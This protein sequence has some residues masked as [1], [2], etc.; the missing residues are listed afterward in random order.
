[1]GATYSSG[2]PM[3]IMSMQDGHNLDLETNSNLARNL[4][5]RA[6]LSIEILKTIWVRSGADPITRDHRFY[7]SRINYAPC[8]LRGPG[9]RLHTRA[10]FHIQKYRINLVIPLPFQWLEGWIWTCRPGYHGADQLPDLEQ[11][12]LSSQDVS[13]HS[14]TG[15]RL[16]AELIICRYH[17]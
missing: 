2:S 6:Q 15:I 13:T 7:A 17:V 9:H 11:I 16:T 12:H 5:G 10:L 8:R 3:V 4:H 14:W 1:M